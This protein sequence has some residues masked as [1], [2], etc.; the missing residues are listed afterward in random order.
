MLLL[1]SGLNIA[2][3]NGVN[4]FGVVSPVRVCWI[5]LMITLLFSMRRDGIEW[6]APTILLFL[7]LAVNVVNLTVA[8]NELSSIATR[9]VQAVMIGVL[10]TAMFVG[11][12]KAR[13]FLAFVSPH[14]STI[15]GVLFLLFVL[16]GVFESRRQRC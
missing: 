11:H 15:C 13:E 4:I 3:L 12:L 14:I 1:T 8:P 5:A 2:W 6:F 7:W 16:L 9:A 10:L